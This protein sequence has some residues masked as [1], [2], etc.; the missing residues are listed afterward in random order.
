MKTQFLRNFIELTKQK[1]FSK[2][3]KDLSISQSTLSHQISQLE[4]E[5]GVNLIERTTKTFKIT[6]AG[7]SNIDDILVPGNFV[8]GS[9]F[10]FN[11]T[12]KSCGSKFGILL[13]FYFANDE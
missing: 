12:W 2:L 8:H 11:G 9:Y 5:L 13:S 10:D 7:N 4:N 3:A 6:E 1:S